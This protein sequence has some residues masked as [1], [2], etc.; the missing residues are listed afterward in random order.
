MNRNMY[1]VARQVT[2]ENHLTDIPCGVCPVISQCCEGGIISPITC[3]Y[4]NE[5]LQDEPSSNG[6]Y[7]TW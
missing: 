7:M 1:R 5:W 6:S 2:I 3:K 4:M